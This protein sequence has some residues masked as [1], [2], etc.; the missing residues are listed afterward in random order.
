PD[1]VVEDVEPAPAGDRRLDHRA[2]LVG[3]RDVGGVSRRLAALGAD[4]PDR[5]LRAL[6]HLIDAEDTRALARDEDRRGLAVA[7]PRRP[8]APAGPR[9]SGSPPCPSAGPPSRDEASPALTGRSRRDPVVSF[10]ST[11]CSTSSG[12]RHFVGRKDAQTSTG[13]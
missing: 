5:L 3:A 8:R 7:D 12:K 6:E 4:Q 1:V 2:A 9:R 11:I 13:R 10:G